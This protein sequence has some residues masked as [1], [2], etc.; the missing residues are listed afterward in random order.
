MHYFDYY[1]DDNRGTHSYWRISTLKSMLLIQYPKKRLSAED[2]N[3]FRRTKCW[4][5]YIQQQTRWSML[6]PTGYGEVTPGVVQQRFGTR[7]Q[8]FLT[9]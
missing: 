4:T 1:Q 8:N 7:L 5:E 3:I 6:F 2:L 9:H